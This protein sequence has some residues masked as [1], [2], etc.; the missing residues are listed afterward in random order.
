MFKD[1]IASMVAD[2]LLSDDVKEEI[3][4]ELNKSIDIP[5]ISEKTERAILE[6]I[7]GVV[8]SIIRKKIGV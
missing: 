8:E 2:D 4:T 3:L 5:I 1:M 6:A 7:W